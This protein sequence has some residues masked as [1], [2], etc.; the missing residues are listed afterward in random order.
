MP[1]WALACNERSRIPERIVQAQAFRQ[2][3]RQVGA[4]QE[5]HGKAGV[6]D[7]AVPIFPGPIWPLG[8]EDELRAPAIPIFVPDRLQI[9]DDGCTFQTPEEVV[10]APCVGL[11]DG[12]DTG[13]RGR[14]G[15]R[16]AYDARQVSKRLLALIFRTSILWGALQS[17]Q[18]GTSYRG[19][20]FFP[21]RGQ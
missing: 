16:S 5:Q 21:W 1:S 12:A 7:I 8:V 2:V 20:L 3:L 15:P 11:E 13:A 10:I 17:P 18:G 6:W 19:A 14:I 9:I 4:A